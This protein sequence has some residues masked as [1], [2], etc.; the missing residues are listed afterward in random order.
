MEL[1]MHYGSGPMPLRVIAERQ[2]VSDSYL[3]QLMAA[4]RKAG[5]V[6]SIRGHMGGYELAMPPDQIVVGDI[7]R[8]L[9]GPIS[10][11]DCVGENAVPCERERECVTRYLWKELKDSIEGVLDNTT[12]QDLCDK[13]REKDQKDSPE[14]PM[15]E[16][17]R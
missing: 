13:A 16:V 8:S 4:L 6:N 12:L 14:V 7:I 3:E 9:E 15:E 10:P 1:A 5:L 2:G 11:M 17:N